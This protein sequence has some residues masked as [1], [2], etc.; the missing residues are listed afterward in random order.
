MEDLS[1]CTVAELRQLLK[2]QGLTV[3]GNK[4]ELISRLKE[5]QEE[6]LVIDEQ[7]TVVVN[8]TTTKQKIIAK[9]ETYCRFC[10]SSLTY[11]SGYSGTLKCPKCKREFEVDSTFDIVSVL[12]RSSFV[13]IVLSIVIALIYSINDG[14][15]GGKLSSG[16][17]AWSICLGGLNLS[18]IIIVFALLYKLAN[19]PIKL[20]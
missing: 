11:P 5:S 15:P 1:S 9:K 20:E 3:S 4:S 8:K 17:A 10:R 6:F 16:I 18:V 14:S 2:E 19:K 13:V 12:F 7:E